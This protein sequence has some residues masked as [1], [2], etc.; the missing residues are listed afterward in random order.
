MQGTVEDFFHNFRQETL[1]SAEAGQNFQ[2]SQFMEDMSAELV[3]TG[4]LEGFEH[5]H[6]RHRSRTAMQVDG[7]WFD[8][9]GILSLLTTDFDS[10]AALESLTKTEINTLFKRL[11]NFFIA[12]LEKQLYEE[13]DETT[14]EY[15]LAR[16]IV[17]RAKSIR[18]L[19]FFLLSEK[20]LSDRVKSLVDDELAGTP[21]SYHIWDMS[22]LHRQ[23]AAAGHKE[24]LDIDLVEL[25]GQGVSCLPAHIG[26]EAF[27][28]YLIVMPGNMLFTIYERYD[29]ALLEQNVRCF[30]QARGKVNKGIRSTIISEPG[31]FF[32][33][34]NGITATARGVTKQVTKNGMEIVGINDLQIVNGGQT[35][36]S[37]FHTSRKDKVSLDKVFVQMKLSIVDNDKNEE[38]IPKISEYAN[39]QNRVNAADFFANHPFHLRIQDFS[40]RLWA[41]ALEGTQRETKWFYERAR[42]QYADAVSTMSTKEQKSFK[43]ANPKLQ[44]FTKTDLAKY[45]NVWDEHPKWV[46]HGAQK[47][48]TKYAGRIAKEWQSSPDIFNEL[49]FKRAIARAILFRKTEKL[50][51]SQPW[52]NGG[53]RANIV[54]YALA[55]MGESCKQKG[56]TID[57]SNIWKAQQVTTA[58]EQGLVVVTAFVSG[59]LIKPPQGISNISEWAKKDACWEQLKEVLPALEE[60]WPIEFVK[61]L[62][63]AK[64][65]GEETSA[66]KK[67]QKIDNGIWAQEE[68]LKLG[69]EHWKAIAQ[70]GIAAQLLSEKEMKLLNTAVQVPKRVPSPSQS[71]ALLEIANKVN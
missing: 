67:L 60:K 38:F 62:V 55:L 32:A 28:S 21:V 36:A 65:V 1:A 66:A 2:L 30:L 8:D 16:Q 7:Y 49:Y 43:T 52:Y 25:C 24:P 15:G 70:K 39:T 69:A 57:Y 13:L 63:S 44:M 26:D 23:A 47:N 48:F 31:M 29:A 46:N 18:K 68:V 14:P 33:Y 12:A 27:E 4:V 58:M 50:V 42:G 10:R 71:K 22:R 53:Y 51:S 6:Y 54:A 11:G 64:T 56:L 5:C 41:P 61:G 9:D 35:T 20:N 40:R 17:D 59:H 3:D 19:N 34:N 37:L 45:E